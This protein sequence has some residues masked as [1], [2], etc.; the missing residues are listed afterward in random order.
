MQLLIHCNYLGQWIVPSISGQCFPPTVRFIIERINHNK[1]IM[2]GGVETDGDG[3]ISTNSI[4][5]FQ[6]SDNTIVSYT[7]IIKPLTVR[8]HFYV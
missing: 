5:L 4:Y 7:S 3:D 6:L 8:I 1:G 2:Y